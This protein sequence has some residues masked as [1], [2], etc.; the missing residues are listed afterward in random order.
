[1]T[2]DISTD[3]SKIQNLIYTIRKRQVMLDEDLAKIY[4]VAIRVLNQAVKRNPARFPSSF[5]F[6]LT[7]EEEQNLRSQI[8][9]IKDSEIK[10]RGKHRKYRPYV[11]TE[12]GVAMLSAVLRSETAINVSIQII[13]AFVKLRR[14]LLEN[15]QLLERMGKI[16]QKQLET[17]KKIDKI[18]NAIEERDITPKKGVFFD[19]QIFDAHVLI[20]KILK[21]AKISIVIIDNYIDE[22][23]LTL[24]SKRKKGVS[25]TIYTRSISKQ[26][27]LDLDK[28][29]RQYEPVTVKELRNVHDRFII[30]DKSKIYHIGASLKDLGKKWF[31]FSKMGKEAL[32]ILEKLK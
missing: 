29:N 32:K 2:K 14:F 9:I 22:T 31:A 12:Q 4:G 24:V 16:E 30:I 1:M 8:V 20:S 27:K 11:F 10:G 7:K 5:M 3:V 28:F 26:F 6:Q 19:G 25:G 13:E 18:F 17:D 15:G 21:S 23:I